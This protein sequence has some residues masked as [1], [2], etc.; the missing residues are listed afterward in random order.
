MDNLA[1]RPFYESLGFVSHP[2]SQ[3]NADEEPL[4]K[5]Y[6][7]A[8]PFFD[9]V[10]G[11]PSHP[12]S[13]IVLAPRGA[14]KTALRRMVEDWAESHGVLAV[15]YD[16]FEFSGGQKLEE[17]GLPYHLRNIIVRILVSYL[18]LL[19]EDPGLILKLDKNTKQNLSVFVH[20]YLGDMTGM[21]FSEILSSLYSVPEKIRDFWIKNVGFLEP[22]INILLKRYGL[23][24]IDLPDLKQEEK[25]LESSY[26]HQLEILRQIVGEAARSS[27]YVLID[28]IDES[29]KTGGSPERAYELIRSIVQ[30][31]DLLGMKGFGFKIFAWDKI[32][33]DFR[34]HARPDRVPQYSL[35]WPRRQ[36]ETLIGARVRAFSNGKFNSFFDIMATNE[37]FNADSVIA[38]F[39]NHSPRSA[40]RICER[41]LAVQA[42][43][44]NTVEQ[45]SWVALDRGFPCS[46]K[47]SRASP[48]EMKFVRI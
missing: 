4:L 2:F 37:G 23:D 35:S 30:D 21:K 31:L 41:V 29:E 33:E 45:I 1:S 28:K 7:I 13:S 15:T 8:P 10:V 36:L 46:Q 17:I 39:A 48:T 18:S 12:N 25:K 5:S 20:S 40:I 43:I 47:K 22:I 34:E 42:D 9:A 14:G 38:L 6:F 16:R 32:Q 44:D 26:K 11:D 27:I 3:T 19:A 24:A